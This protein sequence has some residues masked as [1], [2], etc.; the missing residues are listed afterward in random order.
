M[1]A[2]GSEV[3]LKMRSAIKA[4]LMELGCYVDDELP[5]YVMVMV[6]NKRTRSQMEED[7]QLFLSSNTE[8]FVNWLHQVLQK[9]QEVTINTKL[10]NTLD[11]KKSKSKHGD[12][13]L[14]AKKDHKE[15][16]KKKD[17]EKSKTKQKVKLKAK[18]AKKEKSQILKSHGIS[19]VQNQSN[20]SE[21]NEV[22]TE[23]RV[24]R[25]L[26]RNRF[27]I[28]D[29][30]T[31]S[32]INLDPS[33]Q[34]VDKNQVDAFD[35]PSITEI[36]KFKS[37]SSIDE[38][39]NILQLKLPEVK[40]KSI[41]S[42][43]SGSDGEDFINIRTEAEELME[44][45]IN[46]DN[47]TNNVTK[48]DSCT[49]PLE[50]FVK[51]VINDTTKPNAKG[52]IKAPEP[53]RSDF[54]QIELNLPKR[55]LRERLGA[56]NENFSNKRAINLVNPYQQ[57]KSGKAGTFDE[58]NS[59]LNRLSGKMHFE[60][61]DS[62]SNS[63]GNFRE[64]ISIKERLTMKDK[65]SKNNDTTKKRLGSRV[66]PM[67][68]E[69]IKNNITVA[70]ASVVRAPPR[71]QPQGISAA[72]QLLLRA[73]A[74]AHKS[75]LNMPPKVDTELI[76]KKKALVLPMRRNLNHQKIIIEVPSSNI[77]TSKCHETQDSNSDF[78]IDMDPE[79]LGDLESDNESRLAID[80]S[81]EYVPKPLGNKTDKPKV[82][83]YIPTHIT[84]TT[85]KRALDDA[86]T[87]SKNV[88]PSTESTHEYEK[89]PQFVVTLDGLDPNVFLEKKL[90]MIDQD[91]EIA[92]KPEVEAN[93]EKPPGNNTNITNDN[94]NEKKS[95]KQNIIITFNDTNDS[96]T[97][98]SS[99]KKITNPEPNANK[100][101]D[102][103][104]NMISTNSPET[105]SN[106]DENVQQKKRKA[107]PIIFNKD[108]TKICKI[109]VKKNDG[110]KEDRPIT[111]NKYDLLPSLPP[112]RQRNASTISTGIRESRCRFFPDCRL[113]DSCEFYHPPLQTTPVTKQNTV[114][115]AFPNCTYGS[116]CVYVHPPCKFNSTCVRRDCPYS[117]SERIK[118]SLPI[119][120]T[121]MSPVVASRV[122]AAT[123][124]KTIS[125]ASLPAICK[126]YP[127]CINPTCHW[128][129]PKLCRFGKYC[130]N[131]VEC[132]FYHHDVPSLKW[133]SSQ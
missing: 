3:G 67:Q 131:K 112:D 53:S 19:L 75:I 113:G 61:V 100:V 127:N 107:S 101:V 51:R 41:E 21:K 56:K 85:R 83:D 26:L 23:D 33:I 1:E 95:I 84:S 70:V 37:M 103:E 30:A 2:I 6:A 96:K 126:F 133:K 91:T 42:P 98:K 99:S 90:K 43:A 125:A 72:P 16:D 38:P 29:P 109:V 79:S 73:M 31:V 94:D 71:P 14:I 68:N 110:S 18:K 132:N 130:V 87:L 54:P 12:F 35:I 106:D 82:P 92:N 117:H 102:C 120:N 57:N 4:K 40:K 76:S 24:K 13:L 10:V 52:L 116:K 46:E 93:I 108:D 45:G 124:Y 15:K 58:D 104:K 36:E 129:H 69:P 25:K 47:S 34:T 49:P 74:D 114:C 122:V 63:E 128:Y 88:N 48:N 60:K 65:T 77:P 39:E 118:T 17:K 115:R 44:I 28:I 66:V 86:P 9:L 64:K 27:P 5:D 20:N 62:K 55:P 111:T 97:V 123:N 32:Q 121:L 105:L 89:D 7:L 119:Q 22:D 11:Q 78:E 50:S 8:A 59:F 80:H 81:S